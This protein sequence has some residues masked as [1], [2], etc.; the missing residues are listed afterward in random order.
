MCDYEPWT[1]EPMEALRDAPTHTRALEEHV[2]NLDAQDATFPYHIPPCLF[3]T[4]DMEL[5]VDLVDLGDQ[6]ADAPL[7]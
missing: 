6:G 7:P 2:A 5:V 4:D 1:V 3:Q